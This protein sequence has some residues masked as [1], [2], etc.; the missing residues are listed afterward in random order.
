MF[1][2]QSLWRRDVAVDDHCPLFAGELA[3]AVQDI[4]HGADTQLW[5]A[6]DHDGE[7]ASGAKAV[8]ATLLLIVKP[9]LPIPS[10]TKRCGRV[11]IERGRRWQR[12]QGEAPHS[13]RG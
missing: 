9:E 11:W 2:C 1:R 12:G 7:G 8:E 5:L 3:I 13:R 4:D 10:M 6:V